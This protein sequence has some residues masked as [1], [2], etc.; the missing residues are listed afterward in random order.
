MSYPTRSS[1]ENGYKAAEQ[2]PVFEGYR[3]R[4]L[5]GT[6]KFYY[7][8][9]YRDL[10]QDITSPSRSTDDWS[11]ITVPGNW[12]VQGFGTPIYTNH[13]YEFQPRNPRPPSLPENNP[14]G[15]YRREFEVPQDWIGQE[16]FLNLDGAKSG[17]YV[18]LNGQEIGYSEDSKTSAEFRIDPY[19]KEGTNSLILKIFRWST[20]SYLECQDFWRISGIERDVYLWT[21]PRTALEDFEMLS[22]LD[23]TYTQGIWALHSTLKNTGDQPQ[24][25]T[26]SADLRTPDGQVIWQASQNLTL[27][28]NSRDTV[29]WQ[30]E[31]PQVLAWSAET[32][33]LYRLMMCIEAENGDREY[34][35]YT[36]GFRRFEIRP[37]GEYSE[38]GRP[39][40]L[41]Y[42]NGQPVKM[43]GV[44]THEHNPMTGHYV[45][46][47]LIRK[48]LLLMKQHNINAVRLSHYPQ[49]RRFYELCNEMGLYVY[50]EANLESHGMYYDLSKGG[51]LGNHPE[52]LNVHM[53][54]TINMY[55]RNKNQACVSI[56]SLGNEAGNGYN[57]YQ[58]YLWI[59]NREEGRMNRPVCYERALWEW[60]T[61]MYVPQYPDTTWLKRVGRYGS[62]RPIL[63]S[64]YSHAMGNSSGN[65]SAQWKV[66][67]T[68]PHLQGGFIWDWVDQGLWVE[69]NGD[70]YWAYGGDFG[71]DMPSDGNF[72]CNGIVGPDRRPHP[73]MQEVRY[74][75]QNVGFSNLTPAAEVLSSKNAAIKI[76]N[77]HYFIPL[78][79]FEF[80]Y[81]WLENGKPIQKGD[82]KI[83]TPPQACDTL[84]IP[85]KGTFHPQK[86][87]FLN[88]RMRAGQHPL[89][90]EDCLLG[91]EQFLMQAASTQAREPKPGS[92]MQLEET[93]RAW[94]LSAGKTRFTVDKTSGILIS[95]QVKGKEY[96]HDGFG[97]RPN[98]WRAPT[99]NDY[100]NGAP[101]RLQI[102]KT[103]SRQW[104]VHTITPQRI[105]EYTYRFY[106]DYL[107]SSGN[108]YQV[109]YT[110][111]SDGSIR[112]DAM[113][114]GAEVEAEIPRIGFRFRIP[115]EL[116]TVHYYGRGPE[117][118]YSDR[119]DGSLIGLYTTTVED[120]YFPYVRPQ[121]NGHRTD[122]R[123]LSLSSPKNGLRITGHTSIEF[124][125]L[126]NPIEDFD[127][128]EATQHDYQW[129]NMT[130]EQVANK[131]P[132]AAKDVLRRQHH[133][134]DIQ[135]R[136][137]IEV[138]I[139]HRQ[140]GVAGYNSWGDRPEK[141]HQLS[142]KENYRWGFT[143]TPGK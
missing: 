56:W 10:P 97:L 110:F 137:Y 90:A 42:V 41:F 143:L 101:K 80:T 61:D 126:R 138:C 33:H 95:Y 43:K 69:N 83:D 127:S 63:P 44:N 4:L 32:P 5:N 8:D 125:A 78:G 81:E 7:V 51:T 123:W 25:V 50:D 9:S 11:E 89:L 19:L 23:D 18:Y 122:V 36:V 111:H 31:L 75:Y 39:L 60:N 62:D 20:G 49:G 98:F 77:R 92:R 82:F 99:D 135:P 24:Q 35:P 67:N 128:E 79:S 66:I 131:D 94:V 17:V 139:D 22:T 108:H 38:K 91:A 107:L 58:T 120:L 84:N 105:D 76:K 64:E 53:D 87:Y 130:P 48:D 140:Q 2:W 103:S 109:D 102:W 88:I 74:A 70:G 26:F 112:V 27:A 115:K 106:V 68:Y 30:T 114:Q 21:Q 116:S 136:D 100:G 96:L 119:H 6:W 52:W 93:D 55:E 47:D 104:T 71:T 117:E 141:E 54:R 34:V 3:Y 121:E 129:P 124:N 28:A 40:T 133:I 1:A 85:F 15:V 59:K 46:F 113:F 65:L 37:S 134:N 132:Q 45:P 16:I 118:N 57:F 14:V 142:A 86:E 72:V 29:T 12:E 73:A 13:G